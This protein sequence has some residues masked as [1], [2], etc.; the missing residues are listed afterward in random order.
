MRARGLRETRS[1]SDF[2]IEH[3]SAKSQYEVII[4]GW[5]AKKGDRW[6]SGR[7]VAKLV[8]YLL[9]TAALWVRIQTSLK[10]TNWATQAKE[11]PTHSSPPKNIQKNYRDYKKWTLSQIRPSC[12]FTMWLYN[13]N[14]K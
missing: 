6:L 5:V 14:K 7:W 9:A 8:A 10:N 2:Y 4:N 12:G 3:E 11:W 13:N 1:E